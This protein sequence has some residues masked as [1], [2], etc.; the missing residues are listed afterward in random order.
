MFNYFNHMNALSDRSTLLP[1]S[2]DWISNAV[3]NTTLLSFFW[4]LLMCFRSC[5]WILGLLMCYALTGHR[6]IKKKKEKK[7]WS[8]YAPYSASV[9]IVSKSKPDFGEPLDWDCLPFVLT[10]S[11]MSVRCVRVTRSPEALQNSG[12]SQHVEK[13]RREE[14]ISRNIRSVRLAFPAD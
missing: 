4:V 8:I 13:A 2:N 11:I 10:P 6:K 7:R 1:I 9:R 5:F 3:F 12:Q 14:V